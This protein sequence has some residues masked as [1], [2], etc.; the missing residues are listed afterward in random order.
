MHA[1]LQVLSKDIYLKRSL[2]PLSPKGFPIN[3]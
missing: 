3:E 2:N 1:I